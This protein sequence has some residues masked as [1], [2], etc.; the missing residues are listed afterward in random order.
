MSRTSTASGRMVGEQ[1]AGWGARGSRV[2]GGAVVPAAQ[3]RRRVPSGHM[4]H[5][6][7]APQYNAQANG[8]APAPGGVL[9]LKF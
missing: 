7:T 9:K 8:L 5:S 3:R 2:A 4:R 1:G 6:S